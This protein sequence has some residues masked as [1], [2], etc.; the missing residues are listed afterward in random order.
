MKKTCMNCKQYHPL[1][2]ESG[3]C[4]VDRDKIDSG[5]Y[6]VMKHGDL[7]ERW[8]DAGQQYFIRNGWLK[9][10]KSLKDVAQ[11]NP[12]ELNGDDSQPALQKSEETRDE[13]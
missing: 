10:L 3:R 1:D 11:L 2:E 8:K 9:K 12:G 5:S 7:C 6:P 4:R 13:K